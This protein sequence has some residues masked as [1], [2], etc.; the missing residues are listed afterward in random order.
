MIH[1]IAAQSR[2]LDF[3]ET[4]TFS[5]NNGSFALSGQDAVLEYDQKFFTLDGSARAFTV[6]GQDASFVAPLAIS[7]LT[8][9]TA[10]TGVTG[11]T[12]TYT[13]VDIG[14]VTPDR[15]IILFVSKIS[16]SVTV[17]GASLLP[18]ADENLSRA[19]TLTLLGG[20]GSTS[21]YYTVVFEV[22]DNYTTASIVL[23]FSGTTARDVFTHAALVTGTM[24]D[25]SATAYQTNAVG[26]SASISS[27]TTEEGG[28]VLGLLNLVS[29]A[30]NVSWTN[31]TKLTD[32]GTSNGFEHSYAAQ[33]ASGSTITVTASWTSSVAYRLLVAVYR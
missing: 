31:V 30:S 33:K 23:T 3:R 29:T 6:T 19:G 15:K 17:T 7:A 25:K 18:N 2:W 8:H 10:E 16:A 27:V 12:K 26:T 1:G 24:L 22:P 21:H 5:A 9:T 20:N 11:A 13:N 28:L 14:A 32:G 4:L